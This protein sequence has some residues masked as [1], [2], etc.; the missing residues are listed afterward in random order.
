MI[1]CILHIICV[2]NPGNIYFIISFHIIRF[3]IAN[4]LG[5]LSIVFN[6]L[7][8]KEKKR[9][10]KSQYDPIDIETIDKVDF[11]VTEEVVEKEPDLPSNIEDLLGEYYSLLIRQ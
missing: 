9:K 7:G 6:L 8:M 11:W 4:I 2:L 5:L 10:Q 1:L 3:C